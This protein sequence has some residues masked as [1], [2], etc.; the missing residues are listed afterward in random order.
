MPMLTLDMFTYLELYELIHDSGHLLAVSIEG[1][2][3]S[4][5]HVHSLCFWFLNPWCSSSLTLSSVF[6][7]DKQVMLFLN[8]Y[9]YLPTITSI[10]CCT[11]TCKDCSKPTWSSAT[12]S[13]W[14][15]ITITHFEEVIARMESEPSG[16]R[17]SVQQEQTH[18][19]LWKSGH[20]TYFLWCSASLS[21]G[22]LFNRVWRFCY[23]YAFL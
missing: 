7:I 11:D 21:L 20:S 17:F 12:L 15:A 3:Y 19:C 16:I 14:K 1:T 9:P 5:W 2:S 10:S 18:S 13:L 23:W 8:S 22:C 6:G 4:N